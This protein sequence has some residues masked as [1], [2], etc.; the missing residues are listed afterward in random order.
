[1][2][3]FST[4]HS[5]IDGISCV[6][7]KKVVDNHDYD[8][9]NET[10]RK[11]LMK[12]TG[13]ERKRHVETGT[14]V[15]DLSKVAVERLLEKL[16][17]K[18]EE[19]DL[20]VL[21]TQSREYY[22]PSSAII[23]QDKIG[24]PSSCMAFDIGLGCSGYVYGLSIV[25]QFLRSGQFK[26][27]ILVA[28]DVS[29]VSVHYED[30][31]TYPLFGDGTS[32]TAISYDENAGD[33]FYDVQNDGE[34]HE[35]I[36]IRD[37]GAK[38]LFRDDSIEIKNYGEGI[39]R[40]RKDLELN[41]LD[42]FS[43]S[44]KHPPSGIKS[45]LEQT[46]IEL[47]SIDYFVFHQANKLIIETIRKKLKIPAEKVPYSL[48]EYG[49]TSSA[50]IPITICHQ[51]KNEASNKRFLLSGFGVGLSWAACILDTKNVICLDPIE[52]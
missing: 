29:S 40:S 37:G 5:R 33:I 11:F 41:G 47:D 2:A 22:L 27:A 30:K 39:N 3:F 12:T 17:W 20:L 7:P 28:G 15:L 38:N 42:V 23:L 44:I 52:Y 43:F 19:V 50:S 32:A 13:I 16:Q 9:I 14:T 8:Y 46:Q 24:L 1:M 34:N 18:K 26:K 51:L 35:A 10:E 25:G 49:N 6:V 36:I 21:V 4:S 48:Q 45:L 31:S